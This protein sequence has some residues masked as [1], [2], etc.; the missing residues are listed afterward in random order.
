MT[1]YRKKAGSS[2]EAR[3]KAEDVPG[4]KT[5]EKVEQK[6]LENTSGRISFLSGWVEEKK[7]VSQ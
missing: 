7:N 6:K 5:F 3:D 1:H 2:K 4:N